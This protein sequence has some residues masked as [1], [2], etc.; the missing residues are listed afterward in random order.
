MTAAILHVDLDAL[1]PLSPL[2]GEL[3]RL[4]WNDDASD[5]RLVEIIRSE[6]QLSARI[7]GLAN[8]VAFSAPGAR[9]VAAIDACLQRIGVRRAALLSAAALFGHAVSHRLSSKPAQALWL[10]ALAVAHGAQEIARLRRIADLNSPYLLGLLHDLGYFLIEYARAGSLDALVDTTLTEGIAQEE[11]ELR[12]FGADHAELTRRLLEHWELPEELIEPIRLHHHPDLEPL[13]LASL[14][15]GA[16]HLARSEEVVSTLY[17]ELGHPFAPLAHDRLGLETL[18][19]D[20]LALG[21]DALDRLTD[22][23]VAAVDQLRSS[24]QLLAP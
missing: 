9:P 23:V 7:V 6:P 10:H 11:A 5:R 15:L 18:F 13:G 12:L 17:A 21:P 24:A 20:R 1:P 14:L 22:T 16:E 19:G 2:A 3:L 4:D 8:S